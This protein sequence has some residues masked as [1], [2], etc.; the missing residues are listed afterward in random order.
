M[1]FL[2]SLLGIMGQLGRV[3]PNYVQGY[4]QAWQDNWQDA[5][6][7]NQVQRGQM[8]NLFAA[9]AFPYEFNM[10]ADR[11][12]MSR[13]LANQSVGNF[14]IYAQTYP[15][16]TQAAITAAQGKPEQAAFNNYFA[17]NPG[18]L[19]AVS[20]YNQGQLYNSWGYP[21]LNPLE[22][23]RQNV[24]NQAYWNSLQQQALLAAQNQPAPTPAATAPYW[25]N[26]WQG[27]NQPSVP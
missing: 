8:A 10:L 16:L 18:A 1:A 6:Q 11:A 24:Q 25:G 20:Q 22:L 5:N 2:G 12:A 15:Y 4:R 21:E 27:T 7:Y 23:A 14:G 13:A 3:V 9:S 19:Q 26:I 17:V